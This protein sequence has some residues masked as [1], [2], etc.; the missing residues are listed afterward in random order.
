VLGRPKKKKII[1]RLRGYHGATVISGSMTGLPFYHT[2]FD[3]PAGP[4]LHTTN[5]HHY[6][7]AEAG[8]SE[9]EFSKKCANDL[10]EMILHE[11]A[12]TIGAFIGEPMLGTG[13]IIPP[14]ENYWQ[15]IQAV[16]KK[17]DIL[18]IADE[19]VCGFGRLGANF[20]SHLY[21]MKP[22]L[23]TVAKGLTSAYLPLSGV[24]VGDKVWD[25]LKQGSDKFGPFSH[26]YTYTAHPLCAAA[27]VA[28]LKVLK[29]LDL[30]NNAK[31]TGQYFNTK[32]KETFSHL[33]FVG[34]VRGQGMLGAIEFVADKE[35]KARFDP[36]L[37]V[38]AQISAACLEQGI[39]ARAMPHGDILGFAPPLV[40]TTDDI[41]VILEK[42][43]IAIDSVHAK[44]K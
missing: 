38:G 43:K 31:E 32:L 15:E 1:A 2:A 10:E 24:I 28:N 44:L 13:G 21:G 6:F 18:L 17:Y 40:T 7:E 27:G 11:G 22:D 35:S 41:D 33:D 19:V 9:A 8:M 39:I 34:E 16:L 3:M 36:S 5:P 23:I 29:E 4:I 20:G 30:V 42:V 37:K 25:V 14:P 12:E 26:G